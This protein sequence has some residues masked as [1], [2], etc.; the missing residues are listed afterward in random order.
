MRLI[1]LNVVLIFKGLTEA[2]AT[3]M[4]CENEVVTVLLIYEE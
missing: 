4:F 3:L 1:R 2:S